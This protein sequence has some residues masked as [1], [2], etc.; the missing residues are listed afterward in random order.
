MGTHKTI[1]AKKSYYS[2]KHCGEENIFI[3]INGEGEKCEEKVILLI[4][5]LRFCY[6]ITSKAKEGVSKGCFLVLN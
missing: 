4:L 6:T 1:R 3:G 2:T 5:V